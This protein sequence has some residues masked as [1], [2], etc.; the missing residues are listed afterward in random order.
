MTNKCDLISRSEVI[1]ILEKIDIG[2]FYRYAVITEIKRIQSIEQPQGDLIG[3]EALKKAIKSYA[4]DQYAE[5]EYL[6][7]CAIMTIIDN[8]PAVAKLQD[9]LSKDEKRLIGEAV[10]YL[11]GAN[12][13]EENGWSKEDVKI[14]HSLCVKYFG[15]DYN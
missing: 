5:N 12:L 15:E 3:R 4:D 2:Q 6:G 14:L 11:L 8:A 1:K 7:E 10:N 9:N 13:D